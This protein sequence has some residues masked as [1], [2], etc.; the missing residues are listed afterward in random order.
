VTSEPSGLFKFTDTDVRGDPRLFDI[1]VSYAI[2]YAGEFE[3][4]RSAGEAAREGLM[5]VGMARGVLNCMRTDGAV[6][7]LLPEPAPRLQ[8]VP[9]FSDRIAAPVQRHRPPRPKHWG[10]ASC[11]ALSDHGRHEYTIDT[12]GASSG[13]VQFTCPGRWS[14]NRRPVKTDAM[15]KVPFVIARTGSFVHLVGKGSYVTWIPP[16]YHRPGMGVWSLHVKLACRYPSWLTNPLL[17]RGCATTLMVI[18]KI[19][20]H[21]NRPT[22]VPQWC[23]YCYAETES[24]NAPS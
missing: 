4:L 8:L 10:N 12:P 2:R 7:H 16:H 20:W 18:D 14:M 23:R 15:I 13:S 9:D 3:F 19:P 1:A 5:T 24:L 17:L 6:A 11:D 21:V 22:N